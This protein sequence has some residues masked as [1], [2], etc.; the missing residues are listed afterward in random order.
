MKN[1]RPVTSSQRHAILNDKRGIYSGRPSYKLISYNKLSYNRNNLKKITVK[2]RS[3]GRKN[4]YRLINFKHLFRNKF[5]FLRLEYDPNRTG[6]IS[7]I[8]IDNKLAYILSPEGIELYSNNTNKKILRIGSSISLDHIPSGMPIYNIEL[9]K[10]KGGQFTRSSGGSSL[11]IGKDINKVFVKLCSG[12]I[13]I[14]HKQCMTTIG[15]VSNVKNKNIKYGKA[16]RMIWKGF[17]SKVRG[18]AKNPI[19]HPHGGGEGKSGC[20][21]QPVNSN[22][23]FSKGMRIKKSKKYYSNIL[24]TRYIK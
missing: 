18:V 14:M 22:G 20:G 10:S 16:G 12:E 4:L 23:V 17:K 2:N 5:I 19:D 7:L 3:T 11:I 9:K 8:K 21:R 1:L 6:Y 15:I 13:R 24:K